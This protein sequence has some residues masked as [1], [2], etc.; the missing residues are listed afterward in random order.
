MEDIVRLVADWLADR[1]DEIFGAQFRTLAGG[2]AIVILSVA[3]F[4]ALP[5]AARDKVKFAALVG[6]L[7]FL[8]IELLQ[9]LE[10]ALPWG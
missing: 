7:A 10:R 6:A 3:G 9:L 1:F 2:L 5:S 8:A 4:S